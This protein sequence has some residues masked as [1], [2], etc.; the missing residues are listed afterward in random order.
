MAAGAHYLFTGPLFDEERL[1]DLRGYRRTYRV[2]DWPED[3]V[4][5]VEEVGEEFERPLVRF[6][7]EYLETVEFRGETRITPRQGRAKT[8]IIRRPNRV[9][10]LVSTPNKGKRFEIMARISDVLY[11]DP[12]VITQFPL[13]MDVINGIVTQDHTDISGG[14]YPDP[15]EYS[16]AGSIWRSSRESP[17]LRQFRGGGRSAYEIYDSRAVGR[18]VALSSRNSSVVYLNGAPLFAY[19]ERILFP[20]LGI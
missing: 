7:F 17:Y 12:E 20:A 14:T 4:E 18:A 8:Y 10:F 11:G 6:R 19:L 3:L 5:E 13:P 15:D 1:N 16:G 9:V 2:E